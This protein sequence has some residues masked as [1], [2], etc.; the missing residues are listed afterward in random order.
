[1]YGISTAYPIAFIDCLFV[2]VS[3]MTVTGLV[4][5]NLSTLS[6]LQQVFLF[7]L[8]NIGGLVSQSP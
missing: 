1:M 5:I 6:T 3:A 8:M 7:F 2:C 4:T